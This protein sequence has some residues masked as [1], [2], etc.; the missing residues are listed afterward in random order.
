MTKYHGIILGIIIGIVATWLY[1]KQT[2]GNA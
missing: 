2:G 1:T